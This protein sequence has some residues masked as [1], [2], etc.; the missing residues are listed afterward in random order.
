MSEEENV[1]KIS[2][3]VREGFKYASISEDTAPGSLTIGT[4]FWQTVIEGMQND[5][6][7]WSA[8]LEKSSIPQA[9]EGK[10]Y[11]LH[12]W[13]PLDTEMPTSAA[14]V[15]NITIQLVDEAHTTA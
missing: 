14:E 3:P 10:K 7:A 6:P 11:A 2:F 4:K 9:G 13:L 5:G 1:Y 15:Y 8:L 12:A